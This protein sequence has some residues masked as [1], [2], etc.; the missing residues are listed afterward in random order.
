ML[1]GKTAERKEALKTF[2]RLIGNCRRMSGMK[3]SN[4]KSG[5]T[6]N[7]SKLKGRPFRVQVY[8][9]PRPTYTRVKLTNKWRQAFLYGGRDGGRVVDGL[10]SDA[11]H[12]TGTR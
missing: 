8:E 12:G 7:A 1:F 2:I 9:M 4:A 3:H 5:K 10:F 6:T 11:E